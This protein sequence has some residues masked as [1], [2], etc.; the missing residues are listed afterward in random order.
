ML[1]TPGIP[2]RPRMSEN[3]IL[4]GLFAH[5]MFDAPEMHP[6]PKIETK[7]YSISG[8]QACTIHHYLPVPLPWVPGDKRA[9]S[10]TN[11]RSLTKADAHIPLGKL[12]GL[13][14]R[15][16]HRGVVLRALP[17]L[18][19]IKI[20]TDRVELRIR[21]GRQGARRPSLPEGGDGVEEEVDPLDLDG[22]GLS[23]VVGGEAVGDGA[24]PVRALHRRLQQR[25]R[26]RR[27]RALHVLRLTS[28]IAPPARRRRRLGFVGWLGNRL[29]LGR[30]EIRRW[31]GYSAREEDGGE[32]EGEATAARHRC[33]FCSRNMGF[34]GRNGLMPGPLDCGFAERR[35]SLW[36]PLFVA[37][38]IFAPWSQNRVWWVPNLRNRLN[39]VPR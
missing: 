34:R 14:G 35:S 27:R 21:R 23:R 33:I 6:H 25:E 5:Y 11:H 1:N 30:R 19:E 7:Y 31:S 12:L 9:Q 22:G 29:N 28:R 16:G 2:L 37:H 4:K 13:G 3:S 18:R 32:G 15:I 24:G 10:S 20:N 39:E 26:H 38:P 17:A 8:K 36:L